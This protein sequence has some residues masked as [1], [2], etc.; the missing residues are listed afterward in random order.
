MD[1]DTPDETRLRSG[2]AELE[3]ALNELRAGRARQEALKQNQGQ[4]DADLQLIASSPD[5]HELILTEVD[6][7]QRNVCRLLDG[8]DMELHGLK[9]KIRGLSKYGP[10]LRKKVVQTLLVNTEAV[11]EM[12]VELEAALQEVEKHN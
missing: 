12:M 2:V 9:S 7:R 8:I 10:E 1:G 11:R 6:D 3:G 4:L 5:E